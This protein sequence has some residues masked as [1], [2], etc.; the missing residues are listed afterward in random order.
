LK[1]LL[2]LRRCKHGS[3]DGAMPVNVGELAAGIYRKRIL[4]PPTVVTDVPRIWSLLANLE[5]ET[6]IRQLRDQRSSLECPVWKMGFSIDRP[7]YI[8]EKGRERT[9]KSVLRCDQDEPMHNWRDALLRD[10]RRKSQGGTS[11]HV[12]WPAKKKTVAW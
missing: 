5:K 2:A 3:T 6:K 1:R 12:T 11:Q 10:S 9:S 8:V 7:M 4:F